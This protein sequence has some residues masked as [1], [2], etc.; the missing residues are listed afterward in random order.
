[1]ISKRQLLCFILLVLL[2]LCGC[3]SKK[4]AV[5]VALITDGGT[6]ED[7]KYNQICYEGMKRY[8][9]EKEIAYGVYMPVNGTTDSAMI[10]IDKAVDNGAKLIICPSYM[11]EEA[12]YNGAKKYKN[13]NFVLVDGMPHNEDFTDYT[14]D[15]NVLP[16]TF[17]EEEAGFLAGY[18]AVRDGY[19]RLA[20]LGGMAED[21]VIKY[22]YGFVQGA[23]Y[24]GIEV[25]EK[26]YIAY[27][28]TGK[29]HENKEVHDLA[30]VFY[31]Y[32]VEA[33]FAYGGS[34][35]NSVMKAA[36]EKSK[37]VIGAD[38]DQAYDSSSVIFSCV[39]NLDDAVYNAVNDYYNGHFEGGSERHLT[40]YEKGVA[41]TM[42]DAKFNQFS[43]IEYDAIYNEL[44][45]KSIVP[46]ASTDNGTTAELELVNT[47]IIYQ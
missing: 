45:S 41:L 13:V 12:V 34:L 2:A 24:A 25:G 30:S 42:D 6:V 16:I 5:E 10:Q 27:T 26:V 9:D 7:Y 1:M 23:D 29:V 32:S 28:Y 47:E 39:K 3:K 17:A 11:L 8:C 37:V 46:Y 44:A 22:G 35:G 20:F 31:D 33:I 38:I 43:D 19:R 15:E 21:S 4:N 18:A 40:C 14:I 36:E